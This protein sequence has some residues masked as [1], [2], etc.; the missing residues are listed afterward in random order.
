MIKNKDFTGAKMSIYNW[1]MNPDV[2]DVTSR[3]AKKLIDEGKIDGKKIKSQLIS[4]EQLQ[5]WG[6]V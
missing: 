3:K 6:I 5:N 1:M 2:P 4:F